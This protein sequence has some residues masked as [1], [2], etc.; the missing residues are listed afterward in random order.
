MRWRQWSPAVARRMLAWGGAVGGCRAVRRSQAYQ[1]VLAA[2]TRYGKT[3]AD[4]DAALAGARLPVPD[5]GHG[6]DHQHRIQRD[7]R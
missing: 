4:T 2:R 3:L 7:H 6:P 1:S 5:P